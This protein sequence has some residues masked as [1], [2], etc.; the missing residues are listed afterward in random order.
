MSK[1]VSDIMPFF[2]RSG[3][4][5]VYDPSKHW[6]CIDDIEIG[7][8]GMQEVTADEYDR[9]WNN[10]TGFFKSQVRGVGKMILCSTM[11]D[12]T[13]YTKF[14][15]DEQTGK[16][17]PGGFFASE[18]NQSWPHGRWT[19]V[20]DGPLPPSANAT[21]QADPGGDRTHGVVD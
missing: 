3:N 1:S 20:P 21:E 18:W 9:W 17:L 6:I 8:I 11:G 10:K 4:R 16:N 5:T 2:D 19:E 13:N 15:W 12:D 14:L 7:F